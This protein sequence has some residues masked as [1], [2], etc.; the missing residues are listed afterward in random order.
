MEF[1][2]WPCIFP[3]LYLPLV[4]ANEDRIIGGNECHEDRHPSLVL[5]YDSMGPYCSGTL[6]NENWVITAA[7]CYKRKSVQLMFGEHNTE[8]Q[9][10]HEQ[11]RLSEKVFCPGNGTMNCSDPL[12]DIM[13][14]KLD[15]PAALTEYV[16]A[17]DPAT[18]CAPVGLHCCVMGWGTITTPEETYPNV[19]YC[20]CI[21]ILPIEVCQAAY[22]WE[23]NEKMI[24]AGVMEG[25][26]DSCRGDSGGPLI[27]DGKLQGIVSEGGFPCAEPAQPGIYTNICKFLDW[28]QAVIGEHADETSLSGKGIQGKAL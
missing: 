19:P 5:I 12:D 14:I 10:G 21:E 9:T 8:V 1:I 20:A 4:A 11:F 7:H 26:K 3:L 2:K 24:C 22:P 28:I 15:S 23:V 25:G 6:I 16:A 17:L 18:T 13:L 27:C